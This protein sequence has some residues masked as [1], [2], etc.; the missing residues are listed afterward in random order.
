MNEK[1]ITEVELKQATDSLVN[2]EIKKN[3]I[4]LSEGLSMHLSRAKALTFIIRNTLESPYDRET[5]QHSA[6]LLWMLQDEIEAA[7]ILA[8]CT[9]QSI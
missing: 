6:Q 1:K 4:E 5:I 8:E 9:A 7:Q 2:Y 3:L